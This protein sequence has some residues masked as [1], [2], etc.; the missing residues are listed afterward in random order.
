M[1]GRTVTSAKLRNLR[2][3]N[4]ERTARRDNGGSQGAAHERGRVAMRLVLPILDTAEREGI[5]RARLLEGLSLP[6]GT[7]DPADV[8]ASIS[9]LDYFRL[10]ETAEREVEE[11]GFALRAA[12]SVDPRSFGAVGFACMTS[13]TLGDAF[14]RAAR[15]H[16]VCTDAAHWRRADLDSTDRGTLR[17]AAPKPAA[18]RQSAIVFEQ[19]GPDGR[20]RCAAVE[21]AL[22]EM[23]CHA[24]F[25]A[26]E[27]IEPVE[28]RFAHPRPAALR[29]F[30]QFF[31]GIVRW[32]APRNEM[33]ILTDV[34]ERP[35]PKA[36]P[37][38]LAYFERQA[39]SMLARVGDA[40]PV[41]DVLDAIVR[42]L[43]SGTPRI[44]DVSKSLQ[45][46]PR[47]LR[48][49]LAAQ[50]ATFHGLLDQARQTMAAR[51][52]ERRE[53]AIGEIAFL[54]GFSEPSPFYRAFRRWFRVS[55][56]EYRS[57]SA[58]TPG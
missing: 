55:P 43:P 49:R 40:G 17:G 10:L 3:A 11:P 36:D 6:P 50:D 22:A 42:A 29:P 39:E 1:T 23:L 34:L 54:L 2:A 28:T 58:P 24:R 48:R 13:P 9:L 51:Y 41:S 4:H 32:S 30:E 21:F 38:L 5:A 12:G 53:L 14:Q 56:E 57:T 26:Q 45:T 35:V 37:H 18:A 19:R 31:G 20:G 44:T 16:V 7:S 27:W 8:T 52:L 33:L 47:T 25:L 46:T 15:Y